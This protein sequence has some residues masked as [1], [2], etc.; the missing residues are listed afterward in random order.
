MAFSPW[1]DSSD[2]SAAVATSLVVIQRPMSA[3]ASL[4]VAKASRPRVLLN[5]A[6][7][8]LP[9]SSARDCTARPSAT[10]SGSAPVGG[11]SDAPGEAGLSSEGALCA[12]IGSMS[13]GIGLGPVQLDHPR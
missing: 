11:E 6:S 4:E 1:R 5:L 2:S 13:V 7:T 8:K 10:R 12:G 3:V 9:T